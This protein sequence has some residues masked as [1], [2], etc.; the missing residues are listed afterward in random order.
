M[1]QT[2]Q[3]SPSSCFTK[4][5]SIRRSSD[6]QQTL[7]LARANITTDDP[8]VDELQI[9]EI[10]DEEQDSAIDHARVELLTAEHE[11]DAAVGST[12]NSAEKR[13]ESALNTRTVTR[14]TLGIWRQ[15][16]DRKRKLNAHD[17]EYGGQQ[18]C[19]D[20][21]SEK[22]RF[23]D[24]AEN[25]SPECSDEREARNTIQT[26]ASFFAHD[27]FVVTAWLLLSTT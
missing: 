6:F 17:E 7:V 9:E 24:P 15:N 3:S 26:L 13:L 12:D 25:Q 1:D 18:K 20:D 5:R 27:F 11:I 23:T 19:S 10:N 4:A 8:G 2:S 21:A 14:T 22:R 16:F